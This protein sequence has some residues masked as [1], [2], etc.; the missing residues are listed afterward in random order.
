MTTEQ[1]TPVNSPSN[2]VVEIAEGELCSYAVEV[3]VSDVGILTDKE[4]LLSIL[5]RAATAG[6]ATVLDE[7]SHVF[8]NGAVTGMLLLSASHLTVHTWPEFSLANID[9]LAYGRLNG[10]LMIAEIEKSLSPERI[11]VS[12]LHRSVR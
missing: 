10:E 12:R 2:D 11:N 6:K 1:N 8:P 9:L 5:R 3:W 7:S 4:A